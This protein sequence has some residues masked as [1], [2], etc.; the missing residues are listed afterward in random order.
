MRI[1]QYRI[2]TVVVPLLAAAVLLLPAF[3]RQPKKDDIE[4]MIKD[5]KSNKDGAPQVGAEAPDFKL[6]RLDSDEVV[7]L[8]VFEGKKPVVLVFGSYT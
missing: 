3:G 1:R 8:A 6:K 5:H 4:R 7:E 2:A